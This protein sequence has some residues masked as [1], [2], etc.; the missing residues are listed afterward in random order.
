MGAS[1]CPKAFYLKYIAHK[2]NEGQRE[3]E[4]QRLMSHSQFLPCPV[5]MQ[6]VR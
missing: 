5:G 3:E 1:P 2:E 6:T 4:K